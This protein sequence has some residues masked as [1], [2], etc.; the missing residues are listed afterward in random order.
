ME[1]IDTA[2]D[3]SVFL[4]QIV[5]SC[6]VPIKVFAVSFLGSVLCMV[7]LVHV[8]SCG[9]NPAMVAAIMQCPDSVFLRVQI[10]PFIGCVIGNFKW[11]PQGGCTMMNE[12]KLLQL[13]GPSPCLQNKY[14]IL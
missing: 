2:L 8:A 10:F 4:K 9:L 7:E 13:I 6:G 11:L 12:F 14:N 3:N 1:Y 5:V